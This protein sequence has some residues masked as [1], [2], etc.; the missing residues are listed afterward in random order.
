MTRSLPVNCTSYVMYDSQHTEDS[1]EMEQESITSKIHRSLIHAHNA[2]GTLQTSS[3]VA[4][5][6]LTHCVELR[7]SKGMSVLSLS[8][9][10]VLDDHCTM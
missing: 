1:R 5:P 8:D 4:I 9:L 2:I 3:Y 6:R 10:T 7:R